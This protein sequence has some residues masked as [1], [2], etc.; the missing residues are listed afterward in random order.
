MKKTHPATTSKVVAKAA[1]SKSGP[2]TFLFVG[3]WREEFQQTLTARKE[4]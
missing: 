3:V 4:Q 1:K 2:L